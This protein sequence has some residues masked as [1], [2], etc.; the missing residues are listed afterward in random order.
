M[1][2]IILDLESILL[3]FQKVFVSFHKAIWPLTINKC[4][5][6]LL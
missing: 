6:P 5:S 4:Q 2:Y 3:D 1:T